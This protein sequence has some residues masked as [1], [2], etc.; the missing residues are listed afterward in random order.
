MVA[1][2]YNDNFHF[3]ACILQSIY[4]ININLPVS[5][6]Y[7]M[8]S[9]TIQN[10]SLGGFAA[11]AGIDFGGGQIDK[12]VVATELLR[13]RDFVEFLIKNNPEFIAFLM[14]YERYDF[15]T[16]IDNFDSEIYDIKEKKWINNAPAFED[17][18]FAYLSTVTIS[19][20]IDSGLIVLEVEQNLKI[21]LNLQKIISEVNNIDRARDYTEA[22]KSLEYLNNQLAANFLN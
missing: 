22:Q 10:N 8:S 3:G 15:K 9:G 21:L 2:I 12:S 19:R 18:Y 20:D 7:S 16:K 6:K 1:D 5:C 11:L 14:A 17:I 13:S 4:L